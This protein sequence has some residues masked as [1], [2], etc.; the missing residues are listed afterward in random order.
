[1]KEKN[2]AVNP[3]IIFIHGL[4]GSYKDWDKIAK[5]F[6]ERHF[7]YCHRLS[8]HEEK[9]DIDSVV[10]NDIEE[11]KKVIAKYE[12]Y[13]LIIVAHSVGG[14]IALEMMKELT[15]KCSVLLINVATRQAAE[16][17]AEKVLQNIERYPDMFIKAHFSKMFGDKKVFLDEYS[18]LNICNKAYIE[19][20]KYILTHDYSHLEQYTDKNNIYAVICDKVFGKWCS[21]RRIKKRYGYYLL[22]EKHL[23]VV[24]SN[25][26][27][28]MKKNSEQIIQLIE[29]IIKECNYGYCN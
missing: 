3:A 5:Y 18:K 26:S 10:I 2:S 14:L 6:E 17:R 29:R 12:L 7:V 25:D 23:L 21:L 24:H 20:M 28:I 11:I 22:Q 9:A 27:F 15:I 1:M 4:L 16:K 13:N 19:F 8:G